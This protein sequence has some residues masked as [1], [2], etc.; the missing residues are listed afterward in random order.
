MLK[1]HKPCHLSWLPPSA[2]GR[3]EES[4]RWL[5]EET[6]AENNVLAYSVH[7]IHGIYLNI[8]AFVLIQKYGFKKQRRTYK[9]LADSKIEWY[10]T[11]L[12]FLHIKLYNS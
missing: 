9:C 8:L 5:C 10:L 12:P 4:G 1:E 2:G 11:L 7:V 6:E 3:V